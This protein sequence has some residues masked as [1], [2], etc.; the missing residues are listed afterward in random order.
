MLAD[1]YA[2]N[3]TTVNKAVGLLEHEGLVARYASR[4]GT[5]ILGK[6]SFPKGLLLYLTSAAHDFHAAL[7]HGVQFAAFRRDYLVCFLSP[8][9]EEISGI[10]MRLGPSVKGI[11]ITGYN[12]HETSR[13]VLYADRIPAP[14]QKIH[15][16]NSDS[17]RGGEMIGKFLAERGHSNV[18]F[19]GTFGSSLRAP[20]VFHG[21]GVH[22]F[23]DRLFIGRFDEFNCISRLKQARERFPGF[24][25]IAC[26]RDDDALLVHHCAERAGL[27][28]TKILLT[29]FGNVKSVQSH[30]PLTTIDQHPFEMGERAAERL[31]SMI[32]NPPSSE[33]WI[34]DVMDV[35]LLVK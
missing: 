22:A 21:L 8:A 19:F 13:P 16:V 12:L 6:E 7:L 31:I 5:V 27:D 34:N 15:T 35:E 18:V 28:R 4:A 17:F 9:E 30:L 3:K 11:L 25:A 20:G 29:G 26:E 14:G 33:R 24:T 10:L 2:V 1:E 23:R 32:E